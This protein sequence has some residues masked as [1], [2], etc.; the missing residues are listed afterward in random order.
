MTDDSS[1]ADRGL[2]AF[3]NP[4]LAPLTSEVAV[5]LYYSGLPPGTPVSVSPLQENAHG[6]MS[7]APATGEKHTVGE[8]GGL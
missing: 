3:V 6:R 5:D 7:W 2:V 8:A 1:S 4:T